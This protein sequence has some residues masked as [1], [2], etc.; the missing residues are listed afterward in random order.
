MTKKPPV[1]PAAHGRP[2]GQLAAAVLADGT[3]LGSPEGGRGR[4]AE[5]Q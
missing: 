1:R 5:A 2:Y 4:G 3:E